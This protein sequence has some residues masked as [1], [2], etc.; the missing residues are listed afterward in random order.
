MGEVEPRAV[1]LDMSRYFSNVTIANVDTIYCYG[2]FH[3]TRGTCPARRLQR[4]FGGAVRRTCADIKRISAGR[5]LDH[6]AALDCI[7]QSG[8]SNFIFIFALRAR[9]FY[10]YLA[11]EIYYVHLQHLSALSEP[12][13]VVST[14]PISAA[15]S[16]CRM[17]PRAAPPNGLC[18]SRKWHD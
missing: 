13:T 18:V 2:V 12:N 8:Q 7:K 3:A 11:T 14:S 10:P 15:A 6:I 1:Y 16:G 9:P 17:A 4:E 5:T